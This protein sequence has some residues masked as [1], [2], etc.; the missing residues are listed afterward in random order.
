MHGLDNLSVARKLAMD[1]THDLHPCELIKRR[2]LD[3][4][5][6]THC[7][8]DGAGPVFVPLLYNWELY[9]GDASDE[10]HF[11][12]MYVRGRGGAS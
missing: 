2:A 4:L 6:Q 5:V 8:A 10:G 7:P 1:D 11:G 3:K 12:N 9:T